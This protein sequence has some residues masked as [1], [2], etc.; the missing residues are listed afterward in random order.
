MYS[1][2]TL[3]YTQVPF[4]LVSSTPSLINSIL[5]SYHPS[6]FSWILVILSDAPLTSST[7]SVKSGCVLGGYSLYLRNTGDLRPLFL[8]SMIVWRG[9]SPWIFS[10]QFNITEP[11]WLAVLDVSAAFIPER[12]KIMYYT[13]CHNY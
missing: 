4:F 7:L 9:L 3:R 12:K 2:F 10:S 13:F 8:H 5:H 1:L 11:P 6:S